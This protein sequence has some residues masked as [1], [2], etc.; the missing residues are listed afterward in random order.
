MEI[1]KQINDLLEKYRCTA[2]ELANASDL[3]VSVIS[4]YRNG[5]RRPSENQLQKLAKGFS[6]I[7]Q[8]RGES[9]N[10]KEITDLP[11]QKSAHM[12]MFIRKFNILVSTLDINMND[13]ARFSNYDPSFISRIRSKQRTI[14]DSY[15]FAEKIGEF[16]N[17]K[18]RNEEYDSLVTVLMGNPQMTENSQQY[19]S[20]VRE[21]LLSENTDDQYSLMPVS[22]ILM[23]IDI[24]NYFKKIHFTPPDLAVPAFDTVRLYNGSHEVCQGELD[25]LKYV[26]TDDNITELYLFNEM[27]HF[28]FRHEELANEWLYLMSCILRK[29]ISVSMIHNIERPFGDILVGIEKMFPL[30]MTGLMKPYYLPTAR[31]NIY[32]H[33]CGCTNTVVMYG[34]GMYGHEKHVHLTLDRTAP[35]LEYYR[36]E[37]NVLLEKSRTLMN[38][39][40]KDK[41]TTFRQFLCA[42]VK[43]SG[44]RNGILSVFPLFTIQEELLLSILHRQNATDKEIAKILDAYYELKNN[45][46]SIL[47]NQTIHEEI[48]VL[49]EEE[50]HKNP[51][52]LSLSYSFIDKDFNYTYEE[53]LEHQ[54]QTLEF[55]EQYAGYT[56]TLNH[57][58]PIRNI[59]LIM[60]KNK[61]V[62][63]SRAG[64]PAI[65]F[66][67]RHPNICRAMENISFILSQQ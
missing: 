5:T 63:I 49:S 40:Q 26:L 2:K 46:V 65:H 28:I 38:I 8:Q 14:A 6:V 22:D 11:A 33:I 9:F 1:S 44:E 61:W 53:Y 3:S 15:S 10:Y 67:I 41:A 18:Y 58:K 17:A 16:L 43:T 37:M 59:N 62:T 25:F 32:Y 66:V 36:K 54:R 35:S 60:H 56:V 45:I 52:P 24:Q 39:Y 47:K 27:P 29:G 23:D 42:D 34:E 12:D 4:R 64:S 31:S 13:F 50:F 7:A 55:A 30:Y 21:W 57:R 48:A 19:I 20:G 51:P